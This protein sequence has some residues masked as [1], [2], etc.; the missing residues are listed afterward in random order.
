MKR[1]V[2]LGVAVLCL[3]GLGALNYN[4]L[5]G[6]GG[7]GS[8]VRAPEFVGGAPDWINTT[9]LTLRSLR[10]RPVLVD[11]WEYTCVNCLRTLPYIAEWNRRYAGLG[12]VIV[13]IHTPEFGFSADRANVE[14][15]VKR[16]GIRYPVLLDNQRKNWSAYANSFWPHHYLIDAAGRIVYD[17]IGEGG[18]GETEQAVQGVLREINPSAKLPP[19]M[20]PVRPEDAPGAV[21]YPVTPELYAGYE[22]GGLG[23]PEGYTRDTPAMYTDLPSGREDGLL[24]AHGL[25]RAER[26]A[27]VHARISADDYLAIR[28]HALGVNAVMRSTDGRPLR[29]YLR[30]DQAPLSREDAG[31]D[32][33][34]DGEGRAYVTVDAPR[35]YSLVK[36]RKFGYRVLQL[37]SVS[38]TLALYAFTF[39]SC[40]MQ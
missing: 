26:E 29:V 27:M 18:Y 33:R 32:V 31:D 14:A 25:W 6:G 36:N 9:P 28:Y 30:Q 40:T 23:S 19:L 2:P 1:Y 10:G 39:T 34:F 37:S 15:A 20:A 7:Q 13:G 17:H 38:D 3:G 22:R 24:Y 8:S 35:M 12:L 21:C 4:Q 5:R 16:L 11:F